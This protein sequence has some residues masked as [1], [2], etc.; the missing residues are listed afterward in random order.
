MGGTL[1]CSQGRK[2]MGTSGTHK[3]SSSK[4]SS[5]LPLLHAVTATAHRCKVDVAQAPA[6]DAATM[7]A[8]VQVG[9]AA[10]SGDNNCC[11]CCCRWSMRL[12]AAVLRPAARGQLLAPLQ[13][14]P[15]HTTCDTCYCCQRQHHSIPPH[16]HLQ[17]RSLMVQPLSSTVTD[18]VMTGSTLKFKKFRPPT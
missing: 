5:L 7:G 17:D 13:V 4:S 12:V 9:A 6:A 11:C 1:L 8:A 3:W 16:T 2:G 18:T 10:V 14:G 15:P